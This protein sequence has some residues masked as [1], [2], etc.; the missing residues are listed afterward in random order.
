LSVTY[1][2]IPKHEVLETIRRIAK[3]NTEQVVFLDHAHMRMMERDISQRQILKALELGN[4][5]DDIV[6]D[7]EAERGWKCKLTRMVTG[8][9]ITAVAKLVERESITCLVVTVW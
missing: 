6:W 5:V 7:T 4:L 9:S 8:E 3:Q 1:L 2:P